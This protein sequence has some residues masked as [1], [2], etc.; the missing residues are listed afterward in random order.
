M[1]DER[2]QS[3]PGS[4][5]EKNEGA[6][7]TAKRF[8]RLYESVVVN[9]NKVEIAGI[10]ML[11][12]MA[13]TVDDLRSSE[14][15][16]EL[17]LQHRRAKIEI[18]RSANNL[19]LPVRNLTLPD[20]D[21]LVGMLKTVRY[22]ERHFQEGVHLINN[23]AGPSSALEKVLDILAVIHRE[24][25]IGEA[26]AAGDPSLPALTG[27]GV[28]ANAR[29]PLPIQMYRKETPEKA[30]ARDATVLIRFL[31]PLGD[32]PIL[33]AK[34]GERLGFSSRRSGLDFG[35]DG[36]ATILSNKEKTVVSYFEPDASTPL[37]ATLTNGQQALI[38]RPLSIDNLFGVQFQAV[39][40]TPEIETPAARTAL[41]R[42]G[43]QIIRG[44]NGGVYLFDRAARN[45]FGFWEEIRG[46]R[47]NYTFNPRGTLLQ[48][49]TFTSGNTI[50]PGEDPSSSGSTWREAV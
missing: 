18:V 25:G 44:K 10:T 36:H 21:Q 28:P 14:P 2:S 35:K 9:E 23:G 43:Y 3:D 6:D 7:A 47:T 39:T 32:S 38:G 11:G 30:F 45:G 13:R 16:N 29:E 22:G 12:N 48:D 42:V 24:A 8:R 1:M 49:G 34:G 26:Q 46:E 5:Q 31:H 17:D 33:K 19:V 15:E 37:T 40:L 41:S 27:G 4:R 20:Y 50:V